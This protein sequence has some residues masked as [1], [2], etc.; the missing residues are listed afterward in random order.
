VDKSIKTLV[1]HGCVKTSDDYNLEG[2]FLGY[3]SSFYYLKHETINYFNTNIK[4]HL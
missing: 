2:T 4:N 3:L 1:Q